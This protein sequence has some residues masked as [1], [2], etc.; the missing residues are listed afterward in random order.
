MVDCQGLITASNPRDGILQTAGS[1]DWED[2]DRCDYTEQSLRLGNRSHASRGML[3]QCEW[4]DKVEDQFHR[5]YRGTHHSRARPPCRALRHFRLSDQ[6]CV[7]GVLSRCSLPAQHQQM[8]SRAPIRKVA[9]V[10]QARAREHP[11][12]PPLGRHSP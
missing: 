6:I 2:M 5:I 11:R 9:P 7:P 1:P 8:A 4:R 12:C 10:W 3:I